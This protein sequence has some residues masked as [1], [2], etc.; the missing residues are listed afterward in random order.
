MEKLQCNI[1]YK[2]VD[3]QVTFIQ[4]KKQ[5]KIVLINLL[6]ITITALLSVSYKQTILSKC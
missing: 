5:L 6:V 3:F 2:Y 4:A 1:R